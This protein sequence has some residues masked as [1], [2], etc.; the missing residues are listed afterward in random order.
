MK[1]RIN[2]AFSQ[3]ETL[4]VFF[5]NALRH[6]RYTG[7][8]EATNKMRQMAAAEAELAIEKAQVRTMARIIPDNSFFVATRDRV[9][10]ALTQEMSGF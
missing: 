7:A 4:I 9:E 2:I 3:L 1:Q 5:H 8:E 10:E 6:R